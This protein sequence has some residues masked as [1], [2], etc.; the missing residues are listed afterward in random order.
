MEAGVAPELLT[1]G[2]IQEARLELT[3]HCNLRCVY[4]A[5]SQSYYRGV[6]MP[7]DL[8]QRAIP[9]IA[10]LASSKLGA[11]H[12]NGHGETTFLSG[13]T[14]TCQ[15]LLDHALPVAMT[16]NLAKEYSEKELRVLACM[17]FINVSIDTSDRDLL[18]R[19]RRK[20]DLNRI[21]TNIKLIRET[22][23][24][25]HRSEP[26]FLFSCGLYDQNTLQIDEFAKF[27]V[28]L[29]IQTVG[30]WNLSTWSANEFPYEY[31]DVPVSDRAYPLD[32]LSDAE[33]R[34]RIDAIQ[35]ALDIL[36]ING[37]NAYINGDFVTPL[38]E[39]LRSKSS[40]PGTPVATVA[41]KAHHLAAGFTRD[42]ID[43]WTYIELGANGDVKP[44][45]AHSPIGN[46]GQKDLSQILDDEPIRQLRSELLGGTLNS[47]CADCRLRAPTKPESLQRRVQALVQDAAKAEPH[48]IVSANRVAILLQSALQ[49][50]QGGRQNEG[51]ILVKQALAID[52][53]TTVVFDSVGRLARADL[54]RILIQVRAP[55]T[56]TWLATVCRA[57]G[58]LQGWNLLLRRYLESAPDAPDRDH[59]L[60]DL[61]AARPTIKSRMNHASAMASNAIVTLRAYVRLRTR[62][63]GFWRRHF[64]S[65]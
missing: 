30:F 28:D 9:L 23:R 59:V 31:T 41:A 19:L 6:D 32:T 35:R 43:P 49:H 48:P 44:C 45:C 12:V 7:A 21:V 26:K 60:A 33:L 65:I 63:R 17:N 37:V 46:V 34:P 39:R 5:V 13:W 14:E 62:L 16:S 25:L 64:N 53:G 50:L 40:K 38:I 47:Q 42:C 1:R 54:E 52:P 15:T 36:K 4:C 55:S 24:Q 56:L 3:T 29:G 20:V 18:R 61:K 2:L 22:A 27:A 8:A 51:L 10:D 57:V 58:D 11:V